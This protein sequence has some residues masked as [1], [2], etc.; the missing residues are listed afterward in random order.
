M[1]VALHAHPD[2]LRY[3]AESALSGFETLDLGDAIEN[4]K[5][6]L[7]S[8][9]AYLAALDAANYAVPVFGIETVKA[10]VGLKLV[11]GEAGVPDLT[12]L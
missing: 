7:R 5:G 1:I 2:Q 6:E 11:S 4:A 3:Y 12:D 9:L 10:G 8:L